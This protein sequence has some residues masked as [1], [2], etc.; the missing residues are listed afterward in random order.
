MQH[1]VIKKSIPLSRNAELD[2]WK[3]LAIIIIVI[4]H[5]YMV[6]EDK[7]VFF[8]QGSLFVEF[9]FIVSGY[10]MALSA[11][12]KP[13]AKTE[14]LGSETASFVFKKIK[15][16]LP[17]Y[18]FGSVATLAANIAYR[19]FAYIFEPG[20]LLRVPFTV[21]FLETS[22]IPAYNITGANW[23]LSAMFLSMLVLYPMLRKWNDLF[24]KVIAP[25]VSIML[26]GYMLRHDGFLEGWSIWYG[27]ACKGIL[28][29]IAGIS[30]GTVVFSASK[31]LETKEIEKG[32]STVLSVLS[33]GS[34]L[35]SVFLL[36][37]GFN[38]KSEA[39]I[40]LLFFVSATV[41]ASRKANINAI[42]QNRFCVY[43]GKL[44]MAVFLTHPACA[45]AMNAVA[46]NFESVAAFQK[47]GSGEFIFAFV[48]TLLSVLLG[49][50]CIAVTD[51]VE[52]RIKAA[53][54]KKKQVSKMVE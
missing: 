20:K 5:S 49:I 8:V 37:R 6:L 9:F 28:R 54:K 44:S 36:C 46:E 39:I 43:L 41:I 3:F 33:T 17:Y 35:F 42:F 48:F 53:Y 10:L 14:N 21:L 40:V 31:W 2:F 52:K 51:P 38:K 16:I 29:A 15:T 24:I 27:Y 45:K 47:T 32:T 23:Y 25:V 50:I 4:H 19:G 13:S 22:G 7:K 34:M 26:Y 11:S 12:K 18:I 1:S 30:L